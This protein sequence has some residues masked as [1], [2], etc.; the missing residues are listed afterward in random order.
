MLAQS[1][2]CTAFALNMTRRVTYCIHRSFGK[3]PFEAMEVANQTGIAAGATVGAL[4]SILTLDPIGGALSVS[5]VALEACEAERYT[6][7]KRG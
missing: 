4:V 1:A 5:Y 7:R 2:L 3:M 6:Q